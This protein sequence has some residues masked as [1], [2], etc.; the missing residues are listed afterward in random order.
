MIRNPKN[1]L[2]AL[3]AQVNSYRNLPQQGPKAP[4]AKAQSVEQAQTPAASPTERGFFDH[5][6]AISLHVAGGFQP[7]VQQMSVPQ[8]EEVDLDWEMP[9]DTPTSLAQST[10]T[11]Q[12]N[13]STITL[14]NDGQG[15]YGQKRTES[16]IVTD[17]E[18]D[19][20]TFKLDFEDDLR[21][22][23]EGTD[24]D[25]NEDTFQ[26]PPSTKQVNQRTQ[27]SQQRSVEPSQPKAHS[28]FDKMA[29]G[30]E[31]A[32]TFDLGTVDMSSV[33]DQFD[34]AMEVNEISRAKAVPKANVHE[35]ASLFEG[36]DQT[37]IAAANRPAESMSLVPVE[38]ARQNKRPAWQPVNPNITGWESLMPYFSNEL[39]LLEKSSVFMRETFQQFDTGIYSW[40]PL[41]LVPRSREGAYG[42]G[43]IQVRLNGQW[44]DLF[45]VETPIDNLGLEIAKDFRIQ[46][47]LDPTATTG[48]TWAGKRVMTIVHEVGLHGL[49]NAAMLQRYRTNNLA[50]EQLRQEYIKSVTLELH[51]HSIRG[52]LQPLNTQYAAI[53]DDVGQA[54]IRMRNWNDVGEYNMSLLSVE[55]RIPSDLARS[56]AHLQ[57]QTPKQLPL[58]F[59]YLLSVSG[60]RK[61]DYNVAHIFDLFGFAFEGVT[62]QQIDQLMATGTIADVRAFASARPKN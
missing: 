30:M 19:S 51:H 1:R 59:T 41:D 45:M 27:F 50:P 53:V 16:A 6:Q 17:E 33:F 28:I 61:A 10:I 43:K 58:A 40:I 36:F 4:K 22:I 11:Q 38:P 35:M 13:G 56:V 47:T 20:D 5:G 3:A 9:A 2:A 49:Q 44:T 34:S 8:V 23:L 60:E 18:P 39:Y 25:S 46:I 29:Q 15:I 12:R 37:A 57:T 7:V 14:T 54:L 24:E 42:E 52:E 48:Q 21:K 62:R 31:Y 55:D 26:L 32:Q